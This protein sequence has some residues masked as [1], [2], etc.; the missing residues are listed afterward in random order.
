MKKGRV[1]LIITTS[2]IALVLFFLID[3]KNIGNS[4]GTTEFVKNEN[5]E[6]VA[7]KLGNKFEE[8]SDIVPNFQL[9]DVDGNLVSL[10]DYRGKIV[11]VNFWA[12]WSEESVDSLDD[13][14]KLNEREDVQV[15]N[16]NV[17]EDYKAIE[18]FLDKKNLDLR[19]LV[20]KDGQIGLD[21]LVGKLPTTYIIDGE[22]KLIEKVV[23]PMDYES[24]V[25][26]IEI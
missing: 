15:L 20:D 22:G 4:V 13:F 12:S 14:A 24:M 5:S 19:I 16:I 8:F 26:K 10:E 21:Y 2:I 11:F 17:R 3:K 25:K 1:I 23:E 6:V 18:K 9:Q 7:E